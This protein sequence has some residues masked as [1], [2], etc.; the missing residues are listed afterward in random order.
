[1]LFKAVSFIAEAYVQLNK[2]SDA[3]AAVNDLRKLAISSVRKSAAT[4]EH[5]PCWAWI[6]HD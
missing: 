5:S 2:K 4:G 3:I 1:M 6:A